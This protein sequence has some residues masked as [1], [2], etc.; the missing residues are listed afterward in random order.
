MS[1]LDYV[2]VPLGLGVMAGYQGWLLYM[3]MKHPTKTVIGINSIN[4]RAW[5]NTMMEDPSKNGILAVQTLR[6]NIM[7]STLL[8][9]TAI[10]LCSL[11]AMLMTQ[12]PQGQSIITTSNTSINF[13]LK[14]FLILVCFLIAFLMNVQSIRFYNHAS[15]LI[16]ARRSPLLTHEYVASM[17]NRGSYFWSIGLRAGWLR[18]RREKRVMSV[19]EMEI[20][21]Y[22][23]LLK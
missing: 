20:Q 8:A 7:A 18:R 4:R 22:V 6:N 5:V 17:I 11:V 21:E 15:I 19:E 10:M 13:S 12:S 23:F 3:V 16:N 14:S 2:L 1:V 9:S